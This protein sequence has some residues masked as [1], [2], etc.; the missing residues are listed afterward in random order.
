[1][2]ELL[3]QDRHGR[4]TNLWS[5]GNTLDQWNSPNRGHFMALCYLHKSLPQFQPGHVFSDPMDCLLQMMNLWIKCHVMTCIEHTSPWTTWTLSKI[6][7]QTFKPTICRWLII[8]MKYQFKFNNF[9]ENLTRYSQKVLLVTFLGIP[10][11]R[12]QSR[13]FS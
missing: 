12:Y 11:A 13:N 6:K 9:E 8:Y 5:S 1:M 10:R 2:F 7:I 3:L 4:W